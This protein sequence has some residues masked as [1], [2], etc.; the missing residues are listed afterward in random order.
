MNFDQ[1]L[2][3]HQAPHANIQCFHGGDEAEKDFAA[4]GK[5][6][7]ALKGILQMVYK[8][9]FCKRLIIVCMRIHN[10]WSVFAK[11]VRDNGEI[12]ST[13]H[14]EPLPH[15]P[16]SVMAWSGHQNNDL[17]KWIIMRDNEENFRVFREGVKWW[18][19]GRISA[20]RLLCVWKY[21]VNNF[22]DG[23]EYLMKIVDEL[24]ISQTREQRVSC[25]SLCAASQF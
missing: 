8:R 24:L 17:S 9:W 10:I 18:G 12:C 16:F 21:P 22:D 6:L 19:W 14:W 13:Y 1:E 7:E 4:R 2:P 15:H 3:T 5:E 11:I 25:K 20:M 23:D